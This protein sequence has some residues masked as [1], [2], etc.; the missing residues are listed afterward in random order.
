MTD[1]VVK[2]AVR[3]RLGLPASDHLP[4]RCVCAEA[5]SDA[6]HFFNC[7]KLRRGATTDRHDAIEVELADAA[8]VAGCIAHRQPRYKMVNGVNQAPDHS[9]VPDLSIVTPVGTTLIDVQVTNCTAP[10]HVTAAQKQLGAARK[11]EA[12][13]KAKYTALA[14]GLGKS[15][16]FQ[17]FVLEVHGAWGLHAELAAQY[18]A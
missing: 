3:V 13:K 15:A 11:S 7:V 2:Q 6:A 18:L 12:A 8:A 14:A 10:S 17:P 1:D 5:L 9:L 16:R 4:A